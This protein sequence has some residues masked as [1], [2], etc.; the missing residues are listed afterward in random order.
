MGMAELGDHI[1]REAVTYGGWSTEQRSLMHLPGGRDLEEIKASGRYRFLTPD[2][3]IAEVRGS[4]DYGPLVMHPLVG[5][6]PVDEAW[7]SVQLLT[8][9]VLARA[10]LIRGRRIGGGAHLTHQY[11]KRDRSGAC[12]HDEHPTAINRQA[13]LDLEEKRNPGNSATETAG[14]R[15]PMR[16]GSSSF[17]GLISTSTRRSSELPVSACV[18]TTSTNRTNRSEL[19]A[20]LDST[21][22][23]TIEFCCPR[24]RRLRPGMLR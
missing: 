19:T 10:D 17:G 15:I 5:G 11:R 18:S 14:T 2:Q 9:A 21:P 24:Q 4:P 23:C 13:H 22:P 20:N 3:L 7:K 1:A 16:C 6:M 8:D 12:G